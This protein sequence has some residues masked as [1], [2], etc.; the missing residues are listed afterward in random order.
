MPGGVEQPSDGAEDGRAVRASGLGRRAGRCG[1]TSAELLRAPLI[2]SQCTELARRRSHISSRLARKRSSEASI[3]V[4]CVRKPTPRQ[5][6]ERRVA[7]A[8]T[9]ITCYRG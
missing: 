5:K 2:R 1:D 9:H 8:V 7:D 6:G 4:V 3:H